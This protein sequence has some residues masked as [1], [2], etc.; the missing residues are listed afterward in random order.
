MGHGRS[1]TAF[2]AASPRKVVSVDVKIHPEL[3]LL[4]GLAVR[5][6]FEFVQAN[7][8][9]VNIGPTDLLFIDTHHVYEQLKAELARHADEAKRWIALHDTTTFG[10]SGAD[11]GRGIWPAVE[12]LVARG[13]WRI[14]YKADF[15]NGLTVLERRR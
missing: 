10:A 14:D 9:E 1:T 13:E 8:L 6:Q 15:N 2:L 11:G 4:Q 5:T 3:H 12:E 7:S